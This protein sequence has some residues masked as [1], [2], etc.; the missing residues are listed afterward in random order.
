MVRGMAPADRVDAVIFFRVA[1]VPATKGSLRPIRTREGKTRLIPQLK[2]S[3]PWQDAVAWAAKAA[4]QSREPYAGPVLVAAR[5]IFAR[6]KKTNLAVPAPDLDKL[7]RAVFD[8]MTGIAYND[9]RQV[10]T[11]VGTGKQWADGGEEPG[12][13]IVVMPLDEK[14]QG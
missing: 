13:E 7:L 8:A 12:V 11:L 14:E 2:R 9:D 5:F 4:M 6:P 10:A 3:K 1:G